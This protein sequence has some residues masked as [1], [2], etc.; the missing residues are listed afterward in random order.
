ML[1]LTGT[2]WNYL[3]KGWNRDSD[4]RESYSSVSIIDVE[5]PFP[6]GTIHL[7]STQN[8]TKN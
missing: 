4:V 1:W 2:V 3:L 8:F 7:V 6:H 5:Q